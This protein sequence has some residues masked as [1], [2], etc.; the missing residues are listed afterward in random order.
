MKECG[1]RVS[2][3][4]SGNRGTGRTLVVHGMPDGILKKHLS[5]DVVVGLRKGAT[6]SSRK[7]EG[8]S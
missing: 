8:C 6:R 7:L 1:A 4:I 3:R 5:I 2:N